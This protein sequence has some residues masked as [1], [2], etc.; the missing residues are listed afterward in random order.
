VLSGVTQDMEIVRDETFGPVICL[1]T[2]NGKEEE[3]IALANDSDYGLCASIFTADMEK[4]ERMARRIRCGQIGIN[5]YLGD[6]SGTPWVGAGKSGIGFL[7]TV[8]GVRQFTIPKSI[9][10]PLA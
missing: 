3:A 6:A 2:F 1:L 10:T 9:S 7:G 5:R 8:E 4:G